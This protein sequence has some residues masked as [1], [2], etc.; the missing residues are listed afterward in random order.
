MS[1]QRTT[2]APAHP[3]DIWLQTK[4]SLS[5]NPP[6]HSSFNSEVGVTQHTTARNIPA[7]SSATSCRNGEKMLLGE[8][9]ERLPLQWQHSPRAERPLCS[10]TIEQLFQTFI[11]LWKLQ[12]FSTFFFCPK[13]GLQGW[14]CYYSGSTGMLKTETPL[15]HCSSCTAQTD[16]QPARTW[17]LPL[18]HL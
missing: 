8:C 16:S 17:I 6:W 1:G 5:V 2:S 13:H 9:E 11:H 12:G 15:C 7:N 18:Q 10:F 3:T 4:V 14:M